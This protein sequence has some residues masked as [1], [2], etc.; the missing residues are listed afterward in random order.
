MASLSRKKEFVYLLNGPLWREER[1]GSALAGLP[2]RQPASG[3]MRDSI[4]DCRFL[5]VN[6][7]KKSNDTSLDHGE[8]RT[9]NTSEAAIRQQLS[10]MLQSKTFVQSDKLS[11]FLRFVVEHVI[12]G[13]PSCLKEY[14]IGAEVYDR[15]PPYHPSQDSIVRTEARR[16]RGKLKEYYDSEGKEDPVY[17]YLRPGSYIPVF[18]ARQDLIGPQSSVDQEDFLPEKSSSIATVILPF[19]DISDNSVSSQYARGI[20]D[21]LSYA[22]MM[23]EGCRVISQSSLTSFSSADHGMTDLMSK[24]GA[25]IAY[26]G[27]VR[28]EGKHLR[29]TA[30]IVDAAGF[31][32]WVKR[33]DAEV[34]PEAPFATEAHIAFTLSAGFDTLFDQ[35]RRL[36]L[37]PV[38]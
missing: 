3:P 1:I 4:P 38:S 8:R 32:L 16:L 17:V 24:L 10:R 37:L 27:S 11:R 30:R 21:E 6:A 20:Q 18:Q 26:E 9:A 5:N 36:S 25:R 19:R 13:N 14:V 34:E 28:A 29:V 23:T 2:R 33:I 31:Q 22:L 7:D 15:R 12:D 35:S